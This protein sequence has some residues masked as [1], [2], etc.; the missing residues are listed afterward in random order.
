MC[1]NRD[2]IR[3]RCLATSVDITSPSQTISVNRSL[4]RWC[5]STDTFHEFGL[6]L[7]PAKLVMCLL[8]VIETSGRALRFASMRDRRKSN[9]VF[10]TPEN[11]HHLGRPGTT[12]KLLP[13]EPTIH[14]EVAWKS[15]KW[16][17]WVILGKPCPFGS[18][19]NYLKVCK[20]HLFWGPAL[21]SFTPFPKTS[22]IPLE[23]YRY[24][25]IWSV[26]N[27]VNTTVKTIHGRFSCNVVCQ[28]KDVFHLVGIRLM[29]GSVGTP[30]L[31][32][33]Q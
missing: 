26:S 17:L 27:V 30:E 29:L 11:S 15:W 28:R 5:I 33:E 7:R 4:K 24:C 1:A 2:Q 3:E 22:E 16:N 6:D 31:E 25:S 10:R 20:S 8:I 12:Q 32:I 18:F 9:P 19:G 13:S 21:W 14:F 23:L